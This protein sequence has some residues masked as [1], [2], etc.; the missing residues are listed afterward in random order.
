[1]LCIIRN[2]FEEEKLEKLTNLQKN[3]F[4]V[5]LFDKISV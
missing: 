4:S 3:L 1:M 5:W 2:V